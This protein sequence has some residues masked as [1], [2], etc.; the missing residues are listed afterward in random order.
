[1]RAAQRARRKV[2]RGGDYTILMSQWSFI[3]FTGSHPLL[4]REK[5][6]MIDH[7]L[8]WTRIYAYGYPDKAWSPPVYFLLAIFYRG[9]SLTRKR[10]PLGPYRRPLPRVLGGS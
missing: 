1:L 6:K 3:V 2:L 5:T 8:R 9:T 4:G 10:N 7:D